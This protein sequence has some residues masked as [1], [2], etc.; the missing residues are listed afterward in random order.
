[1]DA[2]E[3]TQRL[4]RMDTIN[5]PG[6]EMQCARLLQELLDAA[7]FETRLIPLGTDGCRASLVARRG[8]AGGAAGDRPLAFTGHIDVVPLGTRP[9]THPPFD[10]VVRDG[11]IHGRGTSDMKSG[12]AA[13]VCAAIAAPPEA[14]L[15][16]IITAGEETGCDGARALAAG[17]H[18][19]SAGALVVCEPTDNV[20]YVGHKGALWLRTVMEGKTA[21]GSMPERG[22]NAI[23]KAVA[24]IDRITP[25]D[26]RCDR[27]PVLGGPTLNV[28][29][30]H[31]GINI[32]SVPDRAVFEL[33]IRTVP[34]MDH[35]TVRQSLAAQMD[36]RSDIEVLVDLPAVW[37][38]PQTP[39]VR[40]VMDMASRFTG[41][42][43]E[44]RTATYFSDASLLGPALG[45]VPAIILGPGEP[46]MAHQTDEW[47]AIGNIERATQIYGE[48]IVDWMRCEQ[49]G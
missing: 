32:N 9:W 23:C 37:T 41:R 15:L 14:G 8:G 12:I 27:H 6:N 28:G 45:D 5:P 36:E 7:G 22:D 47:C 19:G 11:R 46:S 2:V 20:V 16:L 49:A 39:W 48:M 24:A 13:F 10:A 17:P 38:D 43:A 44:V 29:T 3:L 40:R 35:A 18:L 26:F 1:M 34:S 33:D 31:G 21:H 42:S 30:F 25:F 4:V